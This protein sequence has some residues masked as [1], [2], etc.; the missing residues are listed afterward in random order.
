VVAHD[1]ASD[2]T[3]SVEPWLNHISGAPLIFSIIVVFFSTYK[4]KVCI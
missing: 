4:L 1:L 3:F 2:G